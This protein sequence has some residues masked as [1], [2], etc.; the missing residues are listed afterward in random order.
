V[1]ILGHVVVIVLVIGSQ[2]HRRMLMDGLRV[3]HAVQEIKLELGKMILPG[4]R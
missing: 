4:L 1:E 3:L 2:I